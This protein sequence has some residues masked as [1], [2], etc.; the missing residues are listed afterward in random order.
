MALL[1]V[2][3][4]VLAAGGASPPP[5]WETPPAP[6][7]SAPRTAGAAACCVDDADC[8]ARQGVI[9]QAKVATPTE[10]VAIDVSDLPEG[11]LRRA[12]APGPGVDGAPALRILDGRGQPAPW[13]DGA[14]GEIRVVPPGKLGDIHLRDQ[15][16]PS[17][18]PPE[19]RTQG[20]GVRYSVIDGKASLAGKFDVRSL[21]KG[22]GGTLAFDHLEGEIGDD[23]GITV[24][25]WLHGD[26][27]PLARGVVFAFR[28]SDDDGEKVHLILPE[29]ILGET[30]AGVA[31]HG[32]FEAS[33]RFS[34]SWSLTEYVFPAS[35]G[36]GEL[37]TF[38]VLETQVRSLRVLGLSPPKDE[39]FSVIVDVTRAASEPTAHL[40]LH[41]L[42]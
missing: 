11:T 19:L 14:R 7:A 41:V 31:Q 38:G 6:P 21:S 35:P 30:T 40:S 1:L 25:S 4:G 26:A 32:G 42:P 24:R 34:R 2:A 39:R 15:W 20:F 18:D 12:A 10:S 5:G 3:G 9:D 16:E 22:P 17:F 27:R 28:V 37:A 33:S 23:L 13:K 29:V 36:A 8:C